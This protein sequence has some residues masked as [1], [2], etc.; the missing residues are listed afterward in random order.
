MSL[1]IAIVIVAG[2][3]LG[4]WCVGSLMAAMDQ[5]S[6]KRPQSKPDRSGSENWQAAD[7][8]EQETNRSTPD[9]GEDLWHE[10]LGVPESATLEE[11]AL[12]YKQL[13][14]KY[15]PDKVSSLGDEFKAIA[16]ARSRQINAAYAHFRQLRRVH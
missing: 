2:G 13:M 14:R 9:H 5:G 12:A 7:Q 3:A 10:V 4:Y 16:E 1:D 11:G 6:R 8:G 15:H